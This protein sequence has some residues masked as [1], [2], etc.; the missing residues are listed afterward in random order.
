MNIQISQALKKLFEKHRIV[1]WYDTKKELRSDYEAVNLANVSKIELN[2]NE[3]GIKYRILREQANDKFL[4][5]YEGPQPEDIQNWLLDVQLAQGEFRTDQVSIWLAELELGL[6]FTDVIQ[7]HAVFFQV[8]KQKDTLKKLLKSDDTPGMIRLKMLAV[9]TGAEPRMDV[10]IECLLEELSEKQNDKIN[11]IFQCGL[12]DFLW[13]QMKRCYGYS[14]KTPGIQDFVIELF[15]SCYAMGTDG[16]VKLTGDALVFLKRWKDSRQYESTFEKLSNE[17]AELLNIE[18]Y[19]VQ[20]DFK[21]MIELDYFQLIDRKIISDLVSHVSKKTISVGDCALIVRQRRKGHWYRYFQHLYNALDVASQFIHALDQTELSVN[22]MVQGIENYS[23][24]WFRLDQLYRKFIYHVK[25]SGQTSLLESLNNQIENLYTNNYLLKINDNW[26]HIVDAESKW[27]SS[28]QIKFQKQFFEKYITPFINNKKKVFIIISDAL[29]YEV[30]DE[31]K[32]LI[33]KEDRYDANIEPILSMIPGSTQLCMAALLPNKEIEF[34]YNETG[35]AICDGQ[36]TQGFANR[37]KILSQV[38]GKRITAIKAEE[39]MK[40]NNE[41][42]RILTRDHDAIYI[43]HNRID[44][45]GDKRESE[46]RIFEAVEETLKELV[47]LVKKLTN[48]NA[49]NIIVTSD[50]GFIYQNRAIEE[51][52]FIGTDVEGDEI[53][54]WDRRFIIGKGMTDNKSF[55]KFT[56]AELGL[57]GDI[58]VLI[59]KSINR[60]RLKGSGSR[61]VHGGASLQEVVI[62]VVQIN[63]KRQSDISIVDVEILRGSSSTIT[64]GQLAVVLYQK[65][66][67]NEKMQPRY[68][69]AGIYTETGELISDSHDLTFDLVSENHR[70]RELQIRFVLTRK[71]NDANGQEVI[72]RLDEKLTG[73]SH[74]R[75]YKS[76]RYLMRR[77]FTTDFDF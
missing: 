71:A 22:S 56:S 65:E 2:N 40:L 58:E 32:S 57:K 9:C 53:L 28:V 51:S 25:R 12:K 77:S 68:L 13:E 21:K 75:E 1:F 45:T 70:E 18:Q 42:C 37:L 63:K 59:P 60:L 10:I 62:P 72:L 69:K 38:P 48:A 67:S 76:V 20:R 46:E 73:T 52:D 3:F 15:K 29:R 17:C 34:A 64:S 26:Q 16:T 44:A 6:E 11:L 31:F 66:P 55:K 14:S 36:S 39:Y 74:F 4:I 8:N 33:N 54:Y 27:C 47:K 5:Y 61:Y 50:H 24:L 43:Y 30:G 41:K 7:A 35:I 19:L 49:N 23:R